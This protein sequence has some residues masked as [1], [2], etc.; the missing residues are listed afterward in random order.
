[1]Y[2][3]ISLKNGYSMVLDNDINTRAYT[4]W[5]ALFIGVSA[6]TN[7]GLTP[8]VISDTLTPFGQFVMI[9]LMEFG[10]IGLMTVIYMI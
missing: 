6:L 1:L 3:P 9:I 10:G 2:L 4:Y 8:A 5:D 7:T